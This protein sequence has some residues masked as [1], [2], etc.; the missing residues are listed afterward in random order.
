MYCGEQ[1]AIA[2]GDVSVE[3]E[4]EVAETWSDI[5]SLKSEEG[6]VDSHRHSPYQYQ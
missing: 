2:I 4:E 3:I 6:G 5:V 1:L